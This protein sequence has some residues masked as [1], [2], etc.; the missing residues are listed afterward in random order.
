MAIP[1]IN[2]WQ[3]Y[4]PVA[5]EGLGSSYERIVLNQ[6]LLRLHERFGFSKALESPAFGFTGISGINLAALAQAGCEITL[7]DIDAQRLELIRATWQELGLPL[8]SSLN[9][10]F[11]HL[12]YPDG[13]FDFAFNFSAIWFVKDLRV[14]ISELC[15]VTRG[16][17]LI[18]VPNQDG[19]GFKGQLKGYSAERYPELSPSFIDPASIIHLMQ[20]EGRKLLEWNYIDCPPWPDIGMTKEDFARQLLGKHIP[21]KLKTELKPED[22]LSILPYYQ[23]K[24]PDFEQRM[25]K[26]YPFEKLSPRWFKRYWAHHKYYLFAQ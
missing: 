9:P 4:Y 5:H 6:L 22:A 20:R 2:S 16:A 15:R 24:D 21:N 12:D 1:I 26:L 10:D 14:F 17:I 3:N 25:L 11:M 23:G 19:I 18:C 8:N 7:E 13:S